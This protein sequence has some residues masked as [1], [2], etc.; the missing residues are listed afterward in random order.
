MKR[1][2]TMHMDDNSTQWWVSHP[3]D[4][5]I[6]LPVSAPAQVGMEDHVKHLFEGDGRTRPIS[7][8]R[9]FLSPVFRYEILIN[10]EVR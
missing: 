7:F 4:D 6:Y 9:R 1:I 10:E 3:E 2:K 8:A 5:S